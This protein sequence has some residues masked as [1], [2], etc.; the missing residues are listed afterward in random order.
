MSKKKPGVLGFT[1][2][3]RVVYDR[4]PHTFTT[5]DSLRIIRATFNQGIKTEN[6]EFNREFQDNWIELF[7]FLLQQLGFRVGLTIQSSGIR[8]FLRGTF[9]SVQASQDFVNFLTEAF[10]QIT[11]FWTD[12]R[13]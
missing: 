6:F 9:Q 10:G 4:K 5:K 11:I 1:V 3:G 7:I 2:R 8:E 13:K 12:I